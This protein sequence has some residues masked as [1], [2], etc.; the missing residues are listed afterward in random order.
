MSV[1]SQAATTAILN[2]TEGSADKVYQVS[3]RA[4]GDLWVVEFAYGKR[5]SALKT[6][7]KTQEPVEYKAGKSIFD[8]LVREKLAKGYVP[9]GDEVS[10]TR[11]EGEPKASGILPQLPIALDEGD[12]GAMIT[13]ESWWMQQK[14]DG[15]N[16]LLLIRNGIV[17]GVNRKGQF[18]DVPTEWKTYLGVLPD[19][20][21]AGESC[22]PVFYAFDLLEHDQT[23]LRTRGFRDR[24]FALKRLIGT[25]FNWFDGCEL[26]KLESRKETEKRLR[27]VEAYQVGESKRSVFDRIK[28]EGG[29]GVVFKNVHEPFEIGKSWAIRK[30]KFVESATC[31]VLTVNAQRSVQVGCMDGDGTMVNLGNV[32]IPANHSV[33][34]VGELVEV[35]Y[36][37]RFE[38]GSLEQPVYLGVRTDLEVSDA[39]ISQITRIKLKSTSVA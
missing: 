21:L 19:C 10:Y 5:G 35:R 14:H 2:C 16:R 4:S 15:E 33:P 25:T 23:D 24:Y 6:G 9:Y 39:V 7:T 28:I 30:F 3:L 22:G 29:E 8:K 37:Y 38:Y 27:I 32:T 18:I 1:D 11:A 17:R 26:E 13:N 31:I 20:L 34:S 36:L 12:V